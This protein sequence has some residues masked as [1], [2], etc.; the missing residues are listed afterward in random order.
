MGLGRT[1]GAERGDRTAREHGESGAEGAGTGK[2]KERKRETL[3]SGPHS[4]ERER[5]GE[6]QWAESWAAGPRGEVGCAWG[7]AGPIQ[8]GRRKG[9]L[10]LIA[11]P[12]WAGAGKKGAGRALG[13]V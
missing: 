2:K 7:S 5:E 13:W 12:S 11:G 9:R 8:Q 3:T 1:H 4:L 6:R 10:G